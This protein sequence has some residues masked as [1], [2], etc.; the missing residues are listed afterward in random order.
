MAIK[1]AIIQTNYDKGYGC[2]KFTGI[3]RFPLFLKIQ[4]LIIILGTVLQDGYPMEHPILK[5][6]SYSSEKT[7]SFS[8]TNTDNNT[9]HFKNLSGYAGRFYP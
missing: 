3:R 6:Y 2:L 9:I 1:T 7:T 5:S 4:D 8:E